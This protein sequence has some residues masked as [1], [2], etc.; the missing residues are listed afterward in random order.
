MENT[1]FEYRCPNCNNTPSWSVT[2]HEH[3]DSCQCETSETRCGF[4]GRTPEELE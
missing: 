1:T 4:C 2:D 3:E